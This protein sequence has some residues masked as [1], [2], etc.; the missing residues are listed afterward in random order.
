MKIVSFSWS[1]PAVWYGQKV[2]TCRD[3]WTATYGLKMAGQDVVEAWTYLPRTRR[4]DAVPFA[5][6]KVESC[7][8]EPITA[9]GSS[10][11]DK[12]GFTYLRGEV[13]K[14][15]RQSPGIPALWTSFL[16]DAEMRRVLDLTDP[17]R[18]AAYI[19]WA[20]QTEAHHWVLRFSV[21]ELYR[22]PTDDRRIAAYRRLGLP[23]PVVYPDGV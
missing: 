17:R 5:R 7:R 10:A 21:D 15:L 22:E 8:L 1:W 12:E 14:A 6:L 13:L 19:A 3:Q 23:A 18:W 16:S 9:M 20:A 11:Y 4:P 2:M